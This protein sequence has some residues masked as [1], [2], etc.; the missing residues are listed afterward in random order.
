MQDR[1]EETMDRNRVAKKS[2]IIVLCVA[3]IVAP[4]YAQTPQKPTKS[5]DYLPRNEILDRI[6]TSSGYSKTLQEISC[7]AV[8]ELSQKIDRCQQCIQLKNTCP[9]CCL[10]TDMSAKKCSA[11]DNPA[12]YSCVS[13]GRPCN[14]PQMYTTCSAAASCPTLSLGMN[15]DSEDIAHCLERGCPS[16]KPALPSP[17]VCV[18][19]SIFPTKWICTARDDAVGPQ[20]G[21]EPYPGT[22]DNCAQLTYAYTVAPKSP[23][24]SAL[25]TSVCYEYTQNPALTSCIDACV[26]FAQA[27]ERYSKNVYCCLQDVCCA[28]MGCAGTTTGADQHCTTASCQAR[29]AWAECQ[30]QTLNP[31]LCCNS[32]TT[33]ICSQ[34]TQELNACASGG[35]TGACRSCYREVDQT[36][37][38]SFVAKSNEK[39]VV[40]WSIE[41]DPV[42]TPSASEPPNTFFYTMVQVIQEDTGAIVH[43]SI[44]HER[45]FTGAFSIF[46]ATSVDNP[47][48]FY[49]GKKY[50][51]RLLYFMPALEDYTLTSTVSSMELT[52]LRV[53]E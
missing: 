7:S 31:E 28:E 19:D 17:A 53:K 52:V 1:S 46:S 38:Y 22:I 18:Q 49:P 39:I 27:K 2:L 29:L 26:D 44:A 48:V 36:F 20:A 9:D 43:Q 6:S 21:C 32:L 8:N 4:V 45:A 37:R 16:G 5:I 50:S 25:G 3:W 13:N 51:V 33:D 35:S 24:P 15:C 14:V 40:M 11:E 41:A 10:S 47:D 42:Y 12:L 23:C 34:W 30:P